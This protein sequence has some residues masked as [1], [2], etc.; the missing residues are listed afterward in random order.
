M[1]LKLF[2]EKNIS[3][4]FSFGKKAVLI[5]PLKPSTKTR[6]AE[7]RIDLKEFDTSRGEF[8]E[9]QGNPARAH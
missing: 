1:I 3:E 5:G 4:L 6:P 8:P 9:F 2:E 7:S